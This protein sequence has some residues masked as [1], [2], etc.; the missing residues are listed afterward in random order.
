MRAHI[1]DYYSISSDWTAILCRNFF[2]ERKKERKK[3]EEIIVVIFL[4]E[5]ITEQE[6]G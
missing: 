3:R 2:R 1:I 5:E 4:R 6:K